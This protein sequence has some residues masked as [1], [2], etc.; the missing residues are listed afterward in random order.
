MRN[1][2][3]FGSVRLTNGGIELSTEMLPLVI[4][5]SVLVGVK[6]SMVIDKCHSRK[7]SLKYWPTLSVIQT[8]S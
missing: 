2:Q 5:R 4:I 3:G 6:C 7:K 1:N 8:A